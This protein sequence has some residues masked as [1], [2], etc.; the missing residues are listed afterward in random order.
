MSAT[1]VSN[2][3]KTSPL[4]QTTQLDLAEAQ[5]KLQGKHFL[6]IRR[7]NSPEQVKDLRNLLAQKGYETTAAPGKEGVFDAKLMAAVARFQAE[8]NLAKDGTVGQQTWAALMGIPGADQIPPGTTWLKDWTQFVQRQRQEGKSVFAQHEAPEG[9]DLGAGL[10]DIP[11]GKVPMYKQSDARWGNRELFSGSLMKAKGCAV[12]ALA[13]AL[14]SVR[15]KEITPGDL[16]KMLDAKGGYAKEGEN[17]NDVK[18]NVAGASRSFKQSP[19]DIENAIKAGHGVVMGVDYK[20]GAGT[21]HWVTITEI[22]T[23]TKNRQVFLANDPATGE[24]VRFYEVN[25]TLRSYDGGM[26]DY[27]ATGDVA[28]VRANA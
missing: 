15:G 27:T 26:G 14:S 21:D 13:M 16:D 23:D 20:K 18:W 2:T 1:S 11:Q 5:T 28:Y 25:G 22:A 8:N 10:K 19:A 24:V 9:V 6:S 17:K 7:N 4:P 3:S 12:T